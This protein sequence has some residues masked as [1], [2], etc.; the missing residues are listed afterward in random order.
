MNRLFFKKAPYRSIHFPHLKVA[1][2]ISRHADQRIKQRCGIK[3]KQKR[4]AFVKKASK[5]CLSEGQIPS[6]EEFIPF[7]DYMKNLKK[8]VKSKGSYCSL[9]LYK[10][11]FFPISVD[12]TI[13]TVL[14]NE[15]YK[16]IYDKII[17]VLEEE[18]YKPKKN[19]LTDKKAEA[20]TLE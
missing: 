5:L 6:I 13:I 9:Y 14:T 17:Q 10:D 11:F 2:I 12:G 3:T 15:D 7:K 8:K 4:V 19:L 18:D 16:G 20:E 1:I